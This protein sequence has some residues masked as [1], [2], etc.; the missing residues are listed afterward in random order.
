MLE[1]DVC[2]EG[3]HY[4]DSMLLLRRSDLARLVTAGQSGA[5]CV[6]VLGKAKKGNQRKIRRSR[7]TERR[8]SRYMLSKPLKKG[9]KVQLIKFL[10][11]SRKKE[12]IKNTFG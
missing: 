10:Y 2:S 7:S 11:S 1:L 12:P 8:Q 6:V 4:M 3:K 5:V 9:L